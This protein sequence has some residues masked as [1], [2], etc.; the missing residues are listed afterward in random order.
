MD[1]TNQSPDQPQGEDL[2]QT[3][4]PQNNKAVEDVKDFIKT[5][6]ITIIKKIIA[7]PINGSYE[8][9]AAP[10]KNK[11]SNAI[12]LL[13]LGFVA[14]LLLL[15][16]ATPASVRHYI[17]FSLFI[18][19]TFVVTII[20]FL[21]SV[22]TFAVKSAAGTKITF[23]EE[24][25]TGGLCVIPICIF[26]LLLFI[27]SIIA[28]DRSF[29]FFEGGYRNIVDGSSFMAIA[30]LLYLFLY[31]LTIIQQSLKS[32]KVNDALNWYISPLIIVLSFYLG[33]K[34]AGALFS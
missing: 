33:G 25:L 24:L 28:S 15:Y 1:S 31:I 32:S 20:L 34:I 16:L 6:L 4:V 11:Q 22:C 8:V 23:G 18:K 3:T 17:E 5:K 12:S 13:G 9:F 14:T 7:Q 19:A 2:P 21:I 27:F 26:L 10:D 30:A 29:N